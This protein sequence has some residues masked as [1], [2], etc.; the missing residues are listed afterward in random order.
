[1]DNISKKELI[2]FKNEILEDFKKLEITLNEKI[3]TLNQDMQTFM[4]QS[5]LK[6]QAFQ[7]KSLEILSNKIEEKDTSYLNSFEKKIEKLISSN[8]TDIKNLEKDY[9]NSCNK[10]DSILKN[11]LNFPGLI[12]DSCKFETLRVF[13]EYINKVIKDL[14]D[15]KKIVN[16]DLKNYKDKLNSVS[17]NVKIQLL[18]IESR[19]K[20]FNFDSVKN[21]DNLFQEKIDNFDIKINNIKINSEKN[22]LDINQK[23]DELSAKFDKINEFQN[24]IKNALEEELNKYKEEITKEFSNQKEEFKNIKK[25]FKNLDDVK[26]E[27]N[28]LKRSSKYNN[29]YNVH[30]NIQEFDK[31]NHKINNP[32]LVNQIIKD[33]EKIIETK[34]PE[35]KNM[36]FN[37]NKKNKNNISKIIK[38]LSSDNLMNKD[39]EKYIIKEK[40]INNIDN[41]LIKYDFLKTENIHLNNQIKKIPNI[42][43]NNIRNN[44][45]KRYSHIA[46]MA[47]I[48][49]SNNL[50]KEEVTKHFK[51][52]KISNY[53]T[54]KYKLEFERLDSLENNKNFIGTKSQIIN[55]RENEESQ[56]FIN[57][58]E[59][60]KDRD[61]NISF[62]YYIKLF[63]TKE[64]LKD[65]EILSINIDLFKLLNTK[66]ITLNQNIKD[67][68]FTINKKI[69]KFIK[70]LDVFKDI[71]YKEKNIQFSDKYKNN[72]YSPEQTI[73]Y[74]DNFITFSS[75]KNK[76]KNKNY[77]F[78]NIDMIINLMKKT[79]KNKKNYS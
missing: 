40:N 19:L 69:E 63:S 2:F 20:N 48:D 52:P 42:N 47:Q 41:N 68:I 35:L 13:I 61:K 22:T 73:Y 78:P 76:S 43:L 28:Y 59:E 21:F 51:N 34:M 18:G 31:N 23:Y 67:S 14:V 55:F 33:K 70:L 62:N 77:N 49:N 8:E 60:E 79:M 27:V 37:E 57:S 75:R 39:I 46:S 11:N 10:Y 15:N 71:Y 58:N 44:N 74:K 26:K 45:I 17:A 65:K 36:H 54:S 6:L 7:A 16:G 9:I 64:S 50:K 56:K 32:A 3:L 66:I 30:K 38:S 72:F 12:G 4:S 5:D 25:Y 24:N 1:M 29:Y 53:I